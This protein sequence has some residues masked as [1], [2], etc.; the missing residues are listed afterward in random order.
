ML[1]AVFALLLVSAYADN[2]AVIVPKNGKLSMTI[3]D[4]NVF[5]CTGINDELQI[6]RASRFLRSLGT[7]GKIFLEYGEYNIQGKV[8]LDSN[9]ALEGIKKVDEVPAT[10][11]RKLLQTCNVIAGNCCSN[12]GCSSSSCIANGLATNQVNCN[13]NTCPLQ[14]CRAMPGCTSNKCFGFIECNGMFPNCEYKGEQCFFD[15]NSDNFKICGR[16]K[17]SACEMNTK[18]NIEGGHFAKTGLTKV[19]ITIQNHTASFTNLLQLYTFDTK[20]QKMVIVNGNIASNKL[21]VGKKISIDLTNVQSELIF[22][23]YVTNRNRTWFMGDASRNVD[24]LTHAVVTKVSTTSYKV[25]FE[26]LEGSSVVRNFDD[27]SILVEISSGVLQVYN[28]CQTGVLNI[29]A[30]TETLVCRPANVKTYTDVCKYSDDNAFPQLIFN[31]TGNTSTVMF[32][33]INKTNVSLKNFNVIGDVRRTVLQSGVYFKDSTKVN[34]ENV[35]AIA[36]SR[37]GFRVE[38]T[39]TVDILNSVSVCHS[40]YGFEI[41]NSNA[42]TVTDLS[43]VQDNRIGFRI[44]HNNMLKIMNNVLINNEFTF[45]IRNDTML[46]VNDNTFG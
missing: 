38:T 36:F 32:Q 18:E 16:Q 43:L 9:I 37:A 15:G 33:F 7:S 28:P 3:D 39:D 20:T 2:I 12:T 23:I 30:T 42:V 26:D 46:N 13:K 41:M 21:D 45:D 44:Y 40:N 11:N 8:V 31:Q 29:E 22:A 14:R 1:F 17:N 10:G 24:N 4:K 25:S 6:N 19:D 34:I 27:F 35:K 5:K